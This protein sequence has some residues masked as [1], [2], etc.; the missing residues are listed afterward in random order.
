[1]LEVTPVLSKAAMSQVWKG[2]AVMAKVPFDA[3]SNLLSWSLVVRFCSCQ[4]SDLLLTSLRSQVIGCELQNDD[5]AREIVRG[6]LKA[7][8]ALGHLNFNQTRVCTS[9]PTSSFQD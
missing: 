1:M 7:L 2:L 3:S 5:P 8:E 6:R 4:F 9:I